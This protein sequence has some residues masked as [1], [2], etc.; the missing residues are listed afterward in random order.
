VVAGVEG[1]EAVRLRSDIHWAAGRWRESA[2]QLE[3]LYGERWKAWE[4]LNEIERADVLRAAIGYALGED[5]L[6]QARLREKYAAKMAEGPDS[7]AFEVVAAPLGP[8][9]AE[10]ADI[11]R[12]AAAVDTLEGFLRDLHARFP[13]TG[14]VPAIAPATAPAAPAASPQAD[15]PA[16]AADPAPT[17]SIANATGRRAAR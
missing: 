1:R 3:L 8:S 16:K 2:E 9:G 4:P 10:F 6:G 7:R 12:T 11:A 13:E 5:K 15:A 17:G 14:A